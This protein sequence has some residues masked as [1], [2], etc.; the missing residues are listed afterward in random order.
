MAS[1]YSLLSKLLP[2]AE[3]EGKTVYNKAA[4]EALQNDK[5]AQ[6][7][8]ASQL[9]AGS[10]QPL[11][12]QPFKQGLAGIDISKLPDQN[13][14]KDLSIN[15]DKPLGDLGDS[16]PD[17]S[18]SPTLDVNQ[19]VTGN[20]PAT[21][22]DQST[23]LASKWQQLKDAA[24]YA[25]A[26]AAGT[27]LGLMSGNGTPPAQAAKAPIPPATP[28][29]DNDEQLLSD[30]EKQY[31][32]GS[33]KPGAASP[34]A[35]VSDDQSSA[36]PAKPNDSFTPAPNLASTDKL[37]QLQD[38]MNKA[39]LVTNLARA[40]TQAVATSGGQRVNPFDK[41]FEDQLEQNKNIPAQYQQLVEFQ[42]QDPQSGISQTYRQ[43]ANELGVQVHPGASAAEIAQAFPQIV[44]IKTRE[45]MIEA[46]K[47]IA[48]DRLEQMK[49]N[50][51]MRNMSLA[52]RK[53]Q[54]QQ[55]SYN[56]TVQLLEQMRGSP[57]VSQAEKDIY[58][59]Q[60][61]NSLINSMGGDPNKLNPQQVQLLVN[62]VGK[63]ASGGQSSQ[64]E[65]NIL[66]PNTLRGQFANE[67]QKLS[68]SPSPANAGAF[69]KQYQNYANTI[70]K[71]AQGVIK[72]RYGRIIG[73]RAS[74]FT[75]DQL[76]SLNEQYI[77]RFTN[78]LPGTPA[79]QPPAP[80]AA[81]QAGGGMQ[82]PS[83]DAIAAE[84]ARRKAAKGNQ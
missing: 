6:A 8:L 39:N 55:Q 1:D 66:S 34:K 48:Q 76:G 29:D 31:E 70:T 67:W 73:S 63:I 78:P 32:G 21:Q 60:K 10:D 53:D 59:S 27:G 54:K 62:E 36:A 64:A 46:R 12:S 14:S 50:M 25:G 58:A 24:P 30:L 81:P 42:K 71:D 41:Q 15:L 5:A 68:N 45:D 47:E 37:K 65:L 75:P 69:I 83:Q 61:A 82:L 9:A 79:Y 38:Q 17:S 4:L 35:A 80:P 57:A 28:A 84:I 11:K 26:V 18:K 16:I 56:Q 3:A 40:A 43:M 74:Q 72:D 7:E 2:E 33:A 49:Q 22:A 20:V 77:N 19:D 51:F 13:A 44:N 52:D 23:P